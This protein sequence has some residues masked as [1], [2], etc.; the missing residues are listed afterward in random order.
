MK[1]LVQDSIDNREFEKVGKQIGVT[2]NKKILIN[3]YRHLQEE[4]E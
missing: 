3:A 4:K 1:L 2:L